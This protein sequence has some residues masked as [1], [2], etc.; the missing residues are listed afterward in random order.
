LPAANYKVDSAQLRCGNSNTGAAYSLYPGDRYTQYRY[1]TEGFLTL[2][3]MRKR[4]YQILEIAQADD[5]VSRRFDVFIITLIAL[6]IL[7]IVLESINELVA[8]YE[9]GF[10][11]FEVFSVAVFTV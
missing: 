8:R 11:W 9:T 6:N 4:I 2:P 3:N 10:F 1:L 7:A 5:R